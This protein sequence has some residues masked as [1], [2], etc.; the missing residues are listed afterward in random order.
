MI[1]R[2]RLSSID[3]RLEGLKEVT[4]QQAEEVRGL[5]LVVATTIALV[6]QG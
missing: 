4:Q 2:N 3:L 6:Q 1:N 5:V